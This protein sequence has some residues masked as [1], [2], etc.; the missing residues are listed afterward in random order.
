MLGSGYLGETY[1]GDGFD[2]I[3]IIPPPL[4][5][6]GGSSIITWDNPGGRD[7]ETGLDRGVLYLPNGFAVAWN[8]LT[9]I[10]EKSD[11]DLTPVYYD[12]MKISNLVS[13]GDY[14]ATLKAFTCPEEFLDLEGFSELNPGVFVSNQP[15]GTFCL[16]YRTLEGNDVSGNDAGYKLH[17]VYN[18]VAT[19]SDMTYSTV[20]DTITPVE[21][22]WTITAVPEDI[23]GVR[24]TA[25]LIFDSRDCD[26]GL[27][28]EIEGILYGTEDL[29]AELPSMSDLLTMVSDWYLTHPPIITITDNG[30]GTWTA[31][32]DTPGL[33]ID[34][35]DGTFSISDA[36]AVF[37]GYS[38]R[39]SDTV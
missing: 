6:T 11:A 24:P 5:D 31:Y 35:G 38:Y 26:P 19:P 22:E 20:T 30:D 28:A 39:I 7:Y 12:G 33:I 18:L 29:F 37:A 15:Q 8:G 2:E 3:F 17:V 32:S 1:L 16:S 10:V 23:P 27:L 4:T 25:E 36:T 34:N 21:F 14:S 9:S 13:I